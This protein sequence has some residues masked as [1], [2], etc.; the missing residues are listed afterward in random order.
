M[1]GIPDNELVAKQKA[2]DDAYWGHLDN[3]IHRVFKQNQA[4]A[5]LLEI[6]KKTLI[7]IPTVTAHSTQFQ[8]G[9]A[10]GN[11][12][13]IRKIYLTINNVEKN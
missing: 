2:A 13:F 8:A 12:E 10:E 7:A 11:K 1:G 9:I 5:E 3:L 6:W 4:G